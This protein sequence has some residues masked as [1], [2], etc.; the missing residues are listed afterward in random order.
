SDTNA[1]TT[2][3]T[4]PARHRMPT[5]GPPYD[6]TRSSFADDRA[7]ARTN[8]IGLR[9]EPHPPMPTVMPSRTSATMSS[10]VTRLSGTTTGDRRRR[11]PDAVELA[12]GNVGHDVDGIEGRRVGIGSA[13]DGVGHV[14]LRGQLV[15]ARAALQQVGTQ[16]ADERVVALV[17]EQGVV[18]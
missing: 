15:V 9:R 4:F 13:V 10:I 18:A 6:T 11:G 16:S 17:A 7:S 8:A 12:S 5:S 14:V 2:S 3:R 1:Y